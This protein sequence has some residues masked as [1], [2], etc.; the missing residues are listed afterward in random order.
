VWVGRS[1]RRFEDPALVTGAGRFTGDLPADNIR[2][3]VSFTTTATATSTA[4]T[5]PIKPILND[6]GK[7]G[8][9]T[10]VLLPGFLTLTKP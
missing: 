4:G 1:I 5:Y 3:A 8:N 9:Y 2:A 6:N 7:L 10:P